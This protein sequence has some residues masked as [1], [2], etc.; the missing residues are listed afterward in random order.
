MWEQLQQWGIPLWV[1]GSLV[2]GL[3]V[4]AAGCYGGWRHHR[5]PRQA[6]EAALLT[7]L[8]KAK[9][10]SA[11]L[12]KRCQGL[13]CRLLPAIARQYPVY[14]PEVQRQLQ[15]IAVREDWLEQVLVQVYQGAADSRDFL[16]VW[17]YF[18]QE[19]FWGDLVEL[20]AAREEPVRVT[21]VEII[22]AIGDRR[23]LP[24]LVAAILQPQR[25]LPARVGEVFL[26]FG[27]EAVQLL[28]ALLPNLQETE[29]ELILQVIRE[30]PGDQVALSWRSLLPCLQE[31]NERVREEA[32]QA[33][34]N[35]RRPDAL[36]VLLLAGQDQSWRVRAAV[37]RALSGLGGPEAETLLRSFLQDEAFGVRA[38]AREALGR[39]S[40]A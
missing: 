21:G 36:P 12:Q 5:R 33:L 2:G 7:A 38:N 16:A 25:Y 1:A 8:S 20:L 4:A 13:D 29:K 27:E 9:R 34:G 3:A 14:S 6:G 31:E 30:Y 39:R 10:W 11:G 32:V 37:V 26:A 35:C 24:Y 18:A 40:Y 28:T 17:T 19:D 15:Q 22:T 23:F